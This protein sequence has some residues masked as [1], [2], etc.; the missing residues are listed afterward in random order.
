MVSDGGSHGIPS[1]DPLTNSQKKNP[2]KRIL[3]MRDLIM[4]AGRLMV[5]HEF[6][7]D[8]YGD[9]QFKKRSGGIWSFP[10]I[11]SI[12]LPCDLYIYLLY[13]PLIFLQAS[14]KVNLYIYLLYI[15]GISAEVFSTYTSYI[16]LLYLRVLSWSTSDIFK[17]HMRVLYGGN[18][19]WSIW[20]DTLRSV[21]LRER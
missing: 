2:S 13:I 4:I 11:F 15:R 9:H 1:T 6:F 20:L 3:S 19:W 18:I 7:S 16:Y 14:F 10:A 5:Y 17:Y 12:T 21:M 8:H